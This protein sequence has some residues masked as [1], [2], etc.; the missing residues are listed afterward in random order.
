MKRV[1]DPNGILNPGKMF[2]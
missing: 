2:V 1:F